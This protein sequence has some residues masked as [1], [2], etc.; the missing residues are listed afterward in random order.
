M[1]MLIN[2]PIIIVM[3]TCVVV[4]VIDGYHKVL[5]LVLYVK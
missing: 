2:I 5:S 4:A 3:F 1:Y